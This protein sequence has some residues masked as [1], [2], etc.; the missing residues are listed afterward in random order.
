M[1]WVGLKD[2]DIGKWDSPY[3]TSLPSN[4]NMIITKKYAYTYIDQQVIPFYWQW[5]IINWQHL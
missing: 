2:K 1:D 5:C 3:A 4:N